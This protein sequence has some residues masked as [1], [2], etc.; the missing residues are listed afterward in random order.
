MRNPLAMQSS[1]RPLFGALALSLAA[2]LAACGGGGTSAPA[3]VPTGSATVAPSAPPSGQGVSAYPGTLTFT[4]A[5]APAQAFNVQITGTN[6]G[7]PSLTTQCGTVAT[8]V[9]TANPSAGIYTYTVTPTGAG[10]CTVVFTAGSSS[11]SVGITVGAVAGGSL[12]S[13]NTTLTI[14]AGGTGSFTVTASAGTIAYD[15]AA[16]NGIANVTVASGGGTASTTFNVVPVATGNCAVTA[17]D[18]AFSFQENIIV[19]GTLG[20]NAVIVTPTSLHFSSSSAAAQNITVS[21]QGNIG[22]VSIDESSCYSSASGGARLAFLTLTGVTA[23][24]VVNLPVNATVQPIASN[25][26]GGTC[27]IVFTPQTGS[28][29]TLLV[30]IAP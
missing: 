5:G 23:G 19:Q 15:A 29:A 13:N 8:V 11:A 12:S 14:P 30:S 9:N 7:A 6:A 22:Q 17:Y 28:S 18:G 4:G 3:A 24:T 27:Q 26:G 16:C 25:T 21:K 2:T 20:P 10:G 1:L